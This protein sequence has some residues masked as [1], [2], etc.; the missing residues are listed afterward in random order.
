MICTYIILTSGINTQNY[1]AGNQSLIY[2][3]CIEQKRKKILQFLKNKS[4]QY[5]NISGSSKLCLKNL[6][7]WNL[8]SCFFM[9][10]SITKQVTGT[11]LF[12]N[13]GS[14]MNGFF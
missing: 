11:E 2:Y 14:K 7:Y 6:L 8:K 3:L 5:S 1:L 13:L 9:F 4:K 10:I 12:E